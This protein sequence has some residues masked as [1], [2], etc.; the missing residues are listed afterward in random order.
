MHD[1]KPGN[2]EKNINARVPREECGDRLENTVRIGAVRD[3]VMRDMHERDAKCREGAQRLYPGQKTFVAG[4]R[5]PLRQGAG[6]RDYLILASLNLTCLRTTGSY[7]FS[8][9]F[10]V[11]ARAFFLVT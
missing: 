5:L 8:S 9:S 3:I 6:R 4:G 10:C 7:L 1:D 11:C 2:D